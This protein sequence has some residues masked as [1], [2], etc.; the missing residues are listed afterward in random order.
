[1]NIKVIYH[2]NTNYLKKNEW[3][4]LVISY[5]NTIST[6]ATGKILLYEIEKFISQGNE[7]IIQNYLSSKTFQYPCFTIDKNKYRICIPDTPYFVKVPVLNY[8]LIKGFQVNEEIKFI[9]KNIPLN[10]KLSSDF[11]D[12]FSKYQFQP[13]VVV[14]FHELV[15]CLRALNN[16][17]SNTEEESTIYGIKND[18]LIY[19]NLLIT[20]NGFRKDLK[21]NPRLSHDSQYYYVYGTNNNQDLTKETLKSFFKKII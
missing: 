11:I 16:I 2:P 7:V 3:I 8:K 19:N 10:S 15:H 17:N 1:M 9:S 14:L 21:L 4:E 12:S 5:I 13:I 6:T 20:E 18:A